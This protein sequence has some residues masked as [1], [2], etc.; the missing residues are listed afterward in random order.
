MI[1]LQ[2][3]KLK[4]PHTDRQLKEK[5]C[6]L[7]NIDEEAILSY[8]VTR[9]SVDARKKPEL[10]YVYTAEVQLKRE[11]A[12]RRRIK[13]KNI[14]FV[15]KKAPYR[16]IPSGKRTLP[17]RPVVIGT[18]PAGLFCGYQLAKLGYRPILLERGAD[19]DKRIKDVDNFWKE[20]RL[21]HNS[22]VQFGE[23][24]AGT[25]SDGKLGTLVHDN[26]GRNQEVLRI[27]K[28]WRSGADFI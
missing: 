18:G 12:V 16:A 5:I 8:K 17:A 23:G 27:V 20:G 22:N 25:F 14:L 9:R 15:E 2:Q 19:V 21:N 13:N 26:N 24:G 7:L 6:K 3:I 11:S 4:I 10:F 1:R 28:I